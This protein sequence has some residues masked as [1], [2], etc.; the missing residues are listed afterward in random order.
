MVFF[1]EEITEESE[2]NGTDIKSYIST[3][4]GLI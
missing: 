2:P 4:G 3:D 1:I